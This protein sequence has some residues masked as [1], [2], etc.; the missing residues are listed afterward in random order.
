VL[1]MLVVA[2]AGFV[3]FALAKSSGGGRAQAAGGAPRSPAAIPAR[4]ATELAALATPHEAYAA[5]GGPPLRSISNKRPITGEQTVLPVL[6][7]SGKWLK[8]ELPGRPNGLTGWIERSGTK[9]EYTPWR[10]VVD[11][12]QRRVYAYDAGHVVR[13]FGAVVGA[14]A[15]P[16]PRGQFFVEESVLEPH[17]TP[18]WPYALALSARSNVYTE[19]DGGPGQI[20]IHGL[21]NIGGTPGTSASHGCV[22]LQT[23]DMT[24]LADHIDPG[25]P[26]IVR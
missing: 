6:R 15:T 4:G 21:A 16:T 2:A 10:V 8:V 26:V 3:V 24:W 5:P 9:L 7:A 20:A 11:I 23:A 18:Y 22:R 25:V 19:F 13:S 12:A 14:P 1:L 17:S